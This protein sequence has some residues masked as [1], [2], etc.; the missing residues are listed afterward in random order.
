MMPGV[1]IMSMSMKQIKV[2]I[3]KNTKKAYFPLK[4]GQ[5]LTDLSVM[6]ESS[7]DSSLPRPG[8]SISN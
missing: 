2:V 5:S 1:G 3:L 7:S 6:T 8:S 4:N